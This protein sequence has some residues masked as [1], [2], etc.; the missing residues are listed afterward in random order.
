MSDNTNA[1]PHLLQHALIQ[2]ETWQKAAMEQV[3]THEKESHRRM[4]YL[5]KN[6]SDKQQ[7]IRILDQAF[8]SEDP[9]RTTDQIAF[10]LGKYGVPSFLTSFEKC[11][12]R[13][14]Q[15]TGKYGANYSIPLMRSYILK[16]V[17]EWIII[18]KDDRLIETL[19]EYRKEHITTN[20]NRIG[21]ALL[22]ER[23]AACRFENYIE[24][25]RNPYIP[26]ISVKIS[27][28]FS[29][30]D[31]LAS[32]HTLAILD[33][34]LCQLY[35][36]AITN[37][38]TFANGQTSHKFINL[39]MEEYRDALLTTQLMMK[40]LKKSEFLNLKAGI[41]LQA[42]LPDFSALQDELLS[43]ASARRE[44]G[45]V[46]LKIRLVKGANLEMER[47]ESS[48]R[49]WELAPF[50]SKRETDAH[51]KLMLHKALDPV[52]AKAVHVGVASHNIFDL[53]YAFCLAKENKTLDSLSFE[54]LSG[55]APHVGRVL[56]KEGLPLI[57]YC[58]LV[59]EKDI[60]SAIA[61]LVR[62]LDEN[63]SQG[64][65][66][67]DS[68]MLKVGSDAWNQQKEAFIE[69]HT[70]AAELNPQRHRQQN[71]QKEDASNYKGTLDIFVNEA[72]TDFSL[73]SNQ[74]WAKLIKEKWYKQDSSD[75]IKIPVVIAGK[76]IWNERYIHDC[77]D[78]SQP[79]S[80]IIIA[81]YAQAIK[82]DIYEA[83]IAAKLDLDGWRSLTSENRKIILE[84]AAREIKRK[85][86]DFIGIAAASTGKMFR[87]MDIEI[88]EAIDF[89]IYYPRTVSDIEKLDS[90]RVKGKG[91]T[92]VIAPWN[93]PLSIPAGG[94]FAALAAGNTVILKPS[95]YSV[96][97][98]WMFCQCLWQAGISK[99]VLQFVPCRD[100]RLA[101]ALATHPDVSNVIF[102][103][104]TQTARHMLQQHHDIRLIA[105]TGGKNSTIVTAMA[106]VDQAIK[107]VV[108]SAFSN[109]GQKCSAT[110][111]LIV[112][113]SLFDNEHFAR[114]LSDAVSSLSVG[115]P[116]DFQH[117]MGSLIRP[118][119]ENLQRGLKLDNKESWLVEPKQ[120]GSDHR[121]WSPG[122]K[123]NVEPG[124]FTHMSE[125]FGPILSVMRAT[126]LKEAIEF[127]NSTGYGLTAGLE[128]LD[129][130]EQTYWLDHIQ[131][132]N[133][134]INRSTT[135]AIVHRQPFGGTKMSNY[136]PGFKTG[137]PHYVIPLM[138]LEQKLITIQKPL[139]IPAKL[140]S[141]I[142]MLEE[143]C[144]HASILPEDD[145]TKSNKGH[146]QL[147]LQA[148][149][150]YCSAY[151]TQF[152]RP[153][154]LASL[155]GQDN[156]LKY[157]PLGHIMVRL[158]RDDNVFE[159]IARLLAALVTHNQVS[160][161]APPLMET[162]LNNWFTPRIWNL[163]TGGKGVIYQTDEDIQIQI[164][165][166][167]RIRYAHPSRVPTTMREIAAR[168]GIYIA[169]TP[170]LA[171]GRVELLYYL[172][173]QAISINYHRY[174][175]IGLRDDLVVE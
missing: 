23:E 3:T 95:S 1:L 122:I 69:S 129:S 98:A 85:R 26:Y 8:R 132:G 67:R 145:R 92:V 89:A 100:S 70:L 47:T 155:R 126:N 10:L 87:E 28:L 51:Y 149:Y 24:D 29:Q 58:P 52:N 151:D 22:G 161:S 173:E 160:I 33:Q 139:I 31:P 118:P 50:A 49:E 120:I 57:L 65:F 167:S 39:D 112:E 18:D 125:L 73:P 162:V 170:P 147:T 103:G 134:Y 169:D 35:R 135:G 7:L 102:T 140:V 56:Q 5:V 2:A 93:F 4:A 42:Y 166:I 21:E 66:L 71:R 83:V 55:M 104:S 101:T 15:V 63:T 78:I 54:M 84:H 11:L 9:L 113:Q 133:L 156:V 88:S 146:L 34:R 136:G 91:V 72:D 40:S 158:H 108:H 96:P 174:G 117:F 46:P 75:V 61:Y 143:Q 144:E 53:A 36:E 30:I 94:V 123:W 130:R 38:Y 137:G 97:V 62:R 127:S 37:T 141:I 116:W 45:G 105:E 99:N 164:N 82:N 90:L 32:R 13:L 43:F 109:S 80:T 150:S 159:T 152:A 48:I 12:C 154:T 14:F 81:Q 121:L 41:T 114:Q 148:A 165:T 20:I 168:Q 124:S 17:Q 59:Y 157:R 76:D 68:F 131:A 74:E 86:G 79:S 110:S 175:N 77:Y 142:K 163:I 138:E 44:R 25:L 115:Y 111:L 128:S 6:K 60:T 106:D 16:L 107:N 27:T 172:Q 119:E 19:K 171:E 64:H 153:M